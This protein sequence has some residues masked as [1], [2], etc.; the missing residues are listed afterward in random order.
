MTATIGRRVTLNVSALSQDDPLRLLAG[1]LYEIFGHSEGGGYNIRAVTPPCGSKMIMQT[2]I[3]G[4]KKSEL[5][6]PPT[7]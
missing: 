2:V 1:K 4:V 3:M 5:S 7:K 6:P